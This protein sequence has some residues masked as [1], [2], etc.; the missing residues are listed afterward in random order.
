MNFTKLDTALILALKKI[1]DPSEYCLVVF[2]HTQPVL[3]SAATAMLTSFGVN[4][5]TAQ[6][7]VYTA[8]LSLNAVSELSEQ[9]WVQYLRLSQELRLVSAG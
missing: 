6:R 4:G 8:T 9:P 5:I 7:D 1:K 2:I 3:D